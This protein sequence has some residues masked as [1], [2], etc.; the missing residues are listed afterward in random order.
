MYYTQI[1]FN[2]NADKVLLY[3]YYMYIL[4]II[5]GVLLQG[6][7]FFFKKKKEKKNSYNY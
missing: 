1:A 7:I 4:F 6:T 2:Q 3:M 5:Q